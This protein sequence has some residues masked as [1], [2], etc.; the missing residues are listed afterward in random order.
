MLYTF[1]DIL[2]KINTEVNTLK[3]EGKP[4]SLFAPIDYI[5]ELGGKRVRPV[6]AVMAYNLYKDDIGY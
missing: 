4:E 5:L 1:S 6:L 2:N 3:F